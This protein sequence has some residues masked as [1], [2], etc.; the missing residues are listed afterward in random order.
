M[1]DETRGLLLTPASDI[2]TERQAWYWQDRIPTST[3]CLFAGQGGEGKSTFAFHL[4]A[5]ATR[6][7][8]I[9]DYH[10]KPSPVLVWAGEDRWETIVIPRLI[11]AGANLDS[12]VRLGISSTVDADTLEVTPNLPGDL[13]LVREAIQTTGARLVVL[14]PISSTMEGDLHKEADTRRTLDG[15]A[16]IAHATGCVIICIRHFNKGAGKAS[17]KVSGSHAFRDTARAV[18]LFATDDESG[19]RIMTQDKGNYSKHGTGSMAFT[20]ESTDVRTDDGQVAQV[21]RVVIIGDSEVSVDDIINRAR[22]DEGSHEDRNAAQSFVL[23][24]LRNSDAGEAPAADVIK[25]GRVAGF[26]ENEVKHARKRCKQPRIESRKSGYGRGWVWAI[27][28]EGA[29]EDAEGAGAQESGTLGTF[30]APSAPSTQRCRVCHR[31]LHQ[32][33][34][35]DIH[36]T[37]EAA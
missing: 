14:D 27:S 20:L 34:G 10:G 31:P 1:N 22:D 9:G 3:V 32:A 37:C 17:D 4:V 11:A 23:D 36:P 29:T 18:F 26:T 7:T 19:T 28:D 21:A 6:G 16:R 30:M 33:L 13:D 12:V 2:R 15:L 5:E 25:A 8:L 24:F 35:T